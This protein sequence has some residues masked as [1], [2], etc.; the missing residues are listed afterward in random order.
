MSET[1]CP[2]TRS[3][4]E[5]SEADADVH[6]AGRSR[7][8]RDRT[9][10]KLRIAPFVKRTARVAARSEVGAPSRLPLA[11]D[12]KPSPGRIAATAQRGRDYA[13]THDGP[14]RRLNDL[15]QCVETV[16]R[17][18]IP[19]AISSKTGRLAWRRVHL[20]ARWSSRRIGITDR[21]VYVADSFGRYSGLIEPSPGYWRRIP[22]ESHDYLAVALRNCPR[23]VSTLWSCWTEQVVFLEGWFKATLMPS[24]TDQA[25]GDLEARR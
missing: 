18:N 23:K 11:R 17:E 22:D 9:S 8:R 25:T 1:A 5:L 20:D 19:V 16:L 15:Q 2:S 3:T 13:D 6:A 14:R 12:A 24:A 7:S 21:K 10:S 4:S